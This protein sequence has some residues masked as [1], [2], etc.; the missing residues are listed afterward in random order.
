MA[1]EMA[2]N[3][4]MPIPP[5]SRANVILKLVMI[6]VVFCLVLLA[7]VNLCQ[8]IA[9]VASILWLLLVTAMVW[10]ASRQVGGLLLLLTNWIGD[11]FGRNFV[12]ADSPEVQ[13]RCIRF[14]FELLGLRL[15]ERSI[16]LD[17]I[18][19]LEWTTGQASALAG[20]DMDDWHVWLW[21]DHRDS[22]KTERQRRWGARK[23]EQDLHGIGPAGRKEH[24][25]ILARSLLAFLQTAGVDLVQGA[26]P[27]CFVRRT[28]RE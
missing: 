13:P 18:E 11:L 9:L 16:L 3:L 20:K 26:D 5:K 2:S 8:G 17:R 23:P 12:S 21:Y 19:S 25:E 24:T 1:K 10:S 14:G 28:K 15:V 27:T 22:G 4:Q 6:V 7:V